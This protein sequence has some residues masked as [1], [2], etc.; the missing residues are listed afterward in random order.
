[1]GRV[2]ANL[3]PRIPAAQAP[4]F[5]ADAKTLAKVIA[6]APDD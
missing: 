6:E 3:Q 2:R 5:I 1:M 4:I